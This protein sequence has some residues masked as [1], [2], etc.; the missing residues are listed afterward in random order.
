MDLLPIYISNGTG[1]FILLMLLYVSRTKILRDTQ[2]DRLYSAMVLGVILGCIMEAFSYSIDGQV[3]P[4]SRVLN[5]LANTYL[6]SANLLL[7]LCVLAYVD[8][9]LYGD[10]KRIWKRYK[11]QIV[12][13][14]VLIAANVVNYFVPITYYISEQNVY[15]RRPFSYVYY[16]AIV[17][18][19]VTAIIVKR[20]YDRENGARV[21]F[22]ITLFLA[23]VLIGAGLQFAF[24]GLSL[25]WLASALGLAGMFMMQQN[26]L[27]YIDVLV[28][29]Y[30]RQ[31]LNHV[32]AAWTSR[33]DTFAGAFIDVDSFK[34]INDTLG[35]S[36]GDAALKDVSDI[37][38]KSR[39][40]N[41]WV[42]RYAGD[43]FIVLKRCDTPDGLAAYLENMGRNLDAF[44]SSGRPYQ[45]TLS[46]GTSYFDA[47]DLDAFVKEMD[48]N[49]YAMKEARHQGATD[50]K[51]P[52]AAPALSE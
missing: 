13:G 6:F 33:K 20:R 36:Q 22:S 7:P 35:H 1:I 16:V 18:Y 23:P 49:M 39:L 48:D 42:F 34:R 4:G 38:K 51:Q 12:I 5:Y 50:K 27:A 21:F 9:G 41:E 10:V 30:N 24:Y 14:V 46:Y 2:E 29:T 52:P 19:L 43:E 17:Y 25:A 37:L 11:P 3:F 32:L 47:G 26:E 15:E 28:D 44:N 45:L 40:D 31:Y 8:L